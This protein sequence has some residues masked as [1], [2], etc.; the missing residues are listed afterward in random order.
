[1]GEAVE[2]VVSEGEA[3][4]M[5]DGVEAEAVVLEAEVEAEEAIKIR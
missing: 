4:V 3:A 5:V 1:V 2:V